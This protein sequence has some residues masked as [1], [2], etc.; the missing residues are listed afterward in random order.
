MD[1]LGGHRGH[2]L[3]GDAAWD[4]VPEVGEVGVDVEG[5]AVHRPA[6]AD[7]HTDG[8]DLPFAHP[9]AGVTREAAG[10]G[11]AQIGEDVDH[12]LLYRV[13]IEGDGIGAHGHRDDRVPDELAGPVVGDVPTSVGPHQLGAYGGRVDEHVGR[14]GPD[15]ER[16][17]V[18]VFKQEEVVVLRREQRPLHG[19]RVPVP[20]PPQPTNPQGH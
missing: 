16:E 5:E 12:E 15:P 13:D 6:P 11:Q 18:R 1:A 2:R 20:D 3:V 14:I 19:Q 4:D 9:D 17:H 8:A 10:A 7:P